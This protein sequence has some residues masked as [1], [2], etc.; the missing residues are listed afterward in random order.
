VKIAQLN[1]Q[2]YSRGTEVRDSTSKQASLNILAELVSSG[3]SLSDVQSVLILKRNLEL[4][5]LT[6][7]NVSMLLK[8]ATRVGLDIQLLVL[9]FDDLKRSMPQASIEDLANTLAYRDEV[10][11]LGIV[12]PDLERIVKAARSY[13]NANEVLGSL[14]T[15]GSVKSMEESIAKLTSKKEELDARISSLRSDINDLESKKA[16]IQN[17][18]EEYDYLRSSGFDHPVLAT[19]KKT[20]GQFGNSPGHVLDAVNTYANLINFQLEVEDFQET[21]KEEETK[22][23][24]AKEQNA[25]L[26]KVM[27]MS[28]TLLFDLQ[29]SISGIEDLHE[30]AKK[31]GRPERVYY[32]VSRY[33][34]LT[35]IEEQVQSLLKKRAELESHIKELNIQ[36]EGLRGHVE[37]IKESARSSLQPLSAELSKMVQNGFEK[38]TSVYTKQY[39]DLKK[40]S[41]EYAKRL[42][43]AK[44]F[45]EEVNIARVVNS[46]LKYPD[47]A[48]NL[49]I[50][51]AQLFLDAAEKFCWAKG[52][53]PKISLGEASITTSPMY[54]DFQIYFH[55]LIRAA[56]TSLLRGHIQVGV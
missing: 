53:D 24:T 26:Q 44:I 48:K 21:K 36:L 30:L 23:K 45:E 54:S 52:I 27:D 31:Y 9:L 1:T 2:L 14:N 17:Y 16:T 25:H 51:Y 13:G 42:A 33:G 47:E 19:L 11:R 50:G 56:K 41:E 49:S 12:T 38:I 22:L 35:R 4:A 7:E 32:A 43:E 10:V 37:S 28:N 18:L 20:C 8:E 40:E 5:R 6:I 34:D 55:Q 46:I 39:A 15:F 3:L 29:Y